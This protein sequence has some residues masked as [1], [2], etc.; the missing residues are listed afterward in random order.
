METFKNN[1]NSVN[2]EPQSP[3]STFW[4]NDKFLQYFV[5]RDLTEALKYENYTDKI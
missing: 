3:L 5:A 2:F 1:A 4:F